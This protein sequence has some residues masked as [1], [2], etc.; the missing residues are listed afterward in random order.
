MSDEVW[1]VEKEALLKQLRREKKA[2]L[3]SQQPGGRKRKFSPKK[4]LNYNSISEAKNCEIAEQ[5]KK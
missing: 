4:Y 2:W 5:E 3:V 1:S